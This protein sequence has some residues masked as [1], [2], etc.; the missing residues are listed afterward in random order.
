M[1]PINSRNASEQLSAMPTLC[2]QRALSALGALIGMILV[3]GCTSTDLKR[4]TYQA[5]R[6]GDCRVNQLDEFCQQNYA[7]EYRE[8]A[9]MRRNYL[10]EQQNGD[11]I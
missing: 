11:R 8:Y 3:S 2:V 10:L 6:Q 5:L 4:A 7:N 9:T 1:Y